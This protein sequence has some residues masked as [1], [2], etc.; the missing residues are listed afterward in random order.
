MGSGCKG[1]LE[2]GG[3]EKERSA[4]P[5]GFNGSTTNIVGDNLKAMTSVYGKEFPIFLFLLEER[6]TA[7]TYL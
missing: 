6:Q 7:T 5:E 2:N 4:S 3:C 1:W